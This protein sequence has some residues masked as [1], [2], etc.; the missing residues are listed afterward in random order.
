MNQHFA[1]VVLADIF[2]RFRIALPDG[3]VNWLT[4]VWIL[5]LGATAGLILCAAIWGVLWLLARVPGLGTLS[6]NVTARR[7]VIGV[8]TVALFVASMVW[9]PGLRGA[10]P[11]GPP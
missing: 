3:I 9:L 4:P 7:V 5:C 10:A 11:A 8:L 2:D 6:E 1:P